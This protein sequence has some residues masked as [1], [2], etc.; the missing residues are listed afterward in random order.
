MPQMNGFEYTYQIRNT[1]TQNPNLNAPII[2]ITANAMQGERDKCLAI[3]MNDFITKPI[4][5][6]DLKIVI[7][8]HV[9]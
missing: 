6:D 9:I 1:K 4:T 8:K 5:P 2:A 3:G 7:E